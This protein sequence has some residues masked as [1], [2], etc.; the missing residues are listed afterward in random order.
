MAKIK[1]P[2]DAPAGKPLHAHL[3]VVVDYLLS[4]GNTL[5]H[6][7]RWGSNREGYFCYVAKPIDFERLEASFEFPPTIV[8]GKERNVISCRKTGCVIKTVPT[9]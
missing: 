3:E 7:Y 2:D 4:H 8:M 9:N 6:A 5:S 1:V